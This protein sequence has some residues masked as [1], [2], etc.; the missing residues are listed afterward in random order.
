M[1]PVCSPAEGAC[2]AH[3]W[4]P[5]GTLAVLPWVSSWTDIGF[6]GRVHRLGFPDG[7]GRIPVAGVPPSGCRPDTA[8]AGSAGRSRAVAV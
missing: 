7:R 6:G 2:A 5:L 1:L 3:V 8:C 4:A